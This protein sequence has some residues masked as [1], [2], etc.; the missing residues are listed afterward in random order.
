MIIICLVVSTTLQAAENQGN[1][2]EAFL[3]EYER[4]LRLG[5][6][7]PVSDSNSIYILSE[8]V[9]SD[10]IIP[11]PT[12]NFRQEFG[13]S[14]SECPPKGNTN[15]I[16][17]NHVRHACDVAAEGAGNILVG[18]GQIV[19]GIGNI[20][21]YI[22]NLPSN[23]S[24]SKEWEKYYAQEKQDNASEAQ[25]DPHIIGSADEILQTTEHNVTESWVEV[26]SGKSLEDSSAAQKS[27]E[28]EEK[29]KP[30][31]EDIQPSHEKRTYTSMDSLLRINSES[32][33]IN[34]AVD[35]GSISKELDDQQGK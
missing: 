29:E 20:P 24:S 12:N 17:W 6:E 10:V 15:Y 7:A 28:D 11:T 34:A 16:T 8:Y 3:R 18:V 5:E 33:L 22:S 31:S 1:Q 35:L 30:Q 26:L 4:L 27:C 23:L 2:D 25:Q 9:M 14:E 13:L 32:M 21:T 19:R